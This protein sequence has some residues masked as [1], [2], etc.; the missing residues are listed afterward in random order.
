MH[1][2]S[3]RIVTAAPPSGGFPMKASGP[4]LYDPLTLMDCHRGAWSF[5]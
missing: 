2:E 1:C 3:V 4:A 5:S